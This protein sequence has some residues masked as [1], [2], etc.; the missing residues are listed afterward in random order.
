MPIKR[1]PVTMDGET[2]HSGTAGELAPRPPLL[3]P[4]SICP[5]PHS[6]I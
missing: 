3:F 4:F 1:Y 5:L 6:D 2:T